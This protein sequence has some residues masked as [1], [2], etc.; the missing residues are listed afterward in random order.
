MAPTG[1]AAMTASRQLAISAV[2][3]TAELVS[4]RPEKRDEG[5]AI[6]FWQPLDAG[7]R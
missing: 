2:G 4:E 7:P 1:A 3:A 6:A 5:D